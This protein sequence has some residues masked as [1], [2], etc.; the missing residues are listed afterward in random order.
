[1]E[2]LDYIVANQNLFSLIGDSEVS[3]LGTMSNHFSIL[4]TISAKHKK[5]L[6]RKSQ[7]LQSRKTS[8]MI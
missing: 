8:S 1:M 5:Y 7:K 6:I 3:N 4:A 2:V